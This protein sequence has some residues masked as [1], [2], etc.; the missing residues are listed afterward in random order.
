MIS[1]PCLSWKPELRSSSLRVRS[2][3]VIGHMQE[4]GRALGVCRGCRQPRD[5]IFTKSD[6]CD[7]LSMMYLS[8]H[9]L[10]DEI[11]GGVATA[12]RL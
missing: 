5:I 3:H 8:P 7:P 10:D 6:F 2:F 11:I 12:T 9:N 4:P 1:E